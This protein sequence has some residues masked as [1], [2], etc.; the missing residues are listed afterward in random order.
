MPLTFTVGMLPSSSVFAPITRATSSHILRD[1]MVDERETDV[2]IVMSRLTPPACA[3]RRRRTDDQ[4]ASEGIRG[5]QRSSEVIRGHQRSSEVI[6]GHYLEVRTCKRVLGQVLGTA[7]LEDQGDSN[8]D[9]WQRGP[10][11]SAHQRPTV[12]ISGHQWSSVI[13]SGHQWSSVVI[14]AHQCSS[15]L[16][17][18]HQCSSVLISAHQCSSQAITGHHRSSQAIRGNQRH[19]SPPE[20]LITQRRGGDVE[21]DLNVIE[22]L[23]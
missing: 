11:I 20:H 15:V 16:I 3:I 22:R 5:H 7:R 10:R 13:I 12:I 2:S 21:G 23:G 6:G 14:S 18:A 1:V 19:S 9:R 4:R 17:S 8:L